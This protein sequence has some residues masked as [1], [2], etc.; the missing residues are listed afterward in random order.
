MADNWCGCLRKAFEVKPLRR[1][2]KFKIIGNCRI[3]IGVQAERN[4]LKTEGIREDKGI[5]QRFERDQK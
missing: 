3:Q 2:D 4:M 1:A 5:H